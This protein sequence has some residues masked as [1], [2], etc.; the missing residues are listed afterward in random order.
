MKMEMIMKGVS[1]VS[2][3]GAPWLTPLHL[4]KSTD[5]WPPMLV[6][7]ARGFK[8]FLWFKACSQW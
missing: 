7:V 8:D 5:A 1:R 4:S 2:F 6:G 3:I